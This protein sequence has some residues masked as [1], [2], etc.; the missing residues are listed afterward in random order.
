VV[1]DVANDDAAVLR[2]MTVS[3]VHQL[4]RDQH[5]YEFLTSE[6][7][8]WYTVYI[9]QRQYPIPAS[10]SN[11]HK[12]LSAWSDYYTAAQQDARAA[13]VQCAARMF[14]F[15]VADCSKKCKRRSVET[16]VGSIHREWRRSMRSKAAKAQRLLQEVT[17]FNGF[18]RLF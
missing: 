18:Q 16:S 1:S 3:A 7:T 12:A 5:A 6:F 8:L 11:T 10:I 17:V 13:L 2:P 9:E 15:A 14:K 4:L